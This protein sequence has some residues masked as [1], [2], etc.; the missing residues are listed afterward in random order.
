MTNQEVHTSSGDEGLAPAT[1]V[2]AVR[3]PDLSKDVDIKVEI[4]G[5]E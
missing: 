5:G 1:G 3:V 4:L 2:E